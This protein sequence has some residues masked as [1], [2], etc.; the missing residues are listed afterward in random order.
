MTHQNEIGE[1]IDD[2]VFLRTR[3][4]ADARPRAKR[5]ETRLMRRNTHSVTATRSKN[6]EKLLA[7]WFPRPHVPESV[8]PVPA[9]APMFAL[10]GTGTSSSVPARP[11]IDPLSATTYRLELTVS[12]ELY[13]KIQ[14]L[15][16]LLSH[17]LPNRD[18]AALIE[19]AI[20][21]LLRAE[22]LQRSGAGKPRKRR[23]QK[24]RSRHV[25]VEVQGAVRKRDDSQCT[26]VDAQGRRCTEKCFITF[27]HDT[28]HA[29]GGPATLQ[30][31]RLLCRAH[32]AFTARQVFGEEHIRKRVVYER[33]RAGLV[34]LGFRKKQAERALHALEKR[35][36]ELAV[37][38]V[39]RAA[40]AALTAG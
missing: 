19:R 8:T 5:L 26:F 33:V 17:A 21:E 13:E 18:L 2:F 22:T 30:N 38:P 39:M 28:P 37:E 20:D 25:P 4:D 36:I 24:P 3:F 40:L 35:D 16:N 7:R 31:L 32:N 6:I 29:R 12:A 14:Y 27:E 23:E 34:R 1:G 11:R 10:L 9:V 15:L